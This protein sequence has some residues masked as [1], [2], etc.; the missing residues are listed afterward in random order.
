MDRA[1]ILVP[2]LAL[3]SLTLL[4]LF[5]LGVFRVGGLASGRFPPTY[6]KL[7]RESNDEEPDIVRAISRNY[8]N[9]LELPILF[10]AGCLLAYS[11]NLV[12]PFLITLAWVFVALRVV[13]TAI[14]VTYNRV[15]HRAAVFITSFFVLAGFWVVLGSALLARG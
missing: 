14:H 2:V 9:L 6:Y 3:V 12:S 13:H 1:E 4:V 8:H 11:A 7:F 15:K 5:V 10:Y